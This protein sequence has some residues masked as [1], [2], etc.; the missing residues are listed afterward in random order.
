M[1][2]RLCLTWKGW[3]SAAVY[4][5][6]E[7][8]DYAQLQTTVVLL[9]A[10]HT[11]LEQSGKPAVSAA[12]ESEQPPAAPVEVSIYQICIV[13]TQCKAGR[14]CPVKQL[15]ELSC[16]QRDASWNCCCT[17]LTALVSIPDKAA[18]QRVCT[19]HKSIRLALLQCI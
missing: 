7:S 18:F 2:E 3:V 14:V 15:P 19:P 5:P 6:L 9:D 4:L 13:W 1:L 17:Q 16:M 8:P 11:M 12:R 10:F